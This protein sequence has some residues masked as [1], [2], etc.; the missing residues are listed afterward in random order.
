MSFL[1]KIFSSKKLLVTHSGRFHADDIFAT[2][3]LSLLLDGNIKVVR[4][5]DE[6][7][8]A[9]GDYVYDVG[10][11]YDEAI[12]RFDHHQVGGAG[13]RSNG[14]PYAAFG[15]VWKKYGDVVCGGSHDVAHQI[16]KKLVQ[17]IDANDN[18]MDLFTLKGETAPYLVQD[19]FSLWRPSFT[20]EAEYDVPFMKM[21][22]LAKEMLVREIKKTSDAVAGEAIVIDAYQRALDKRIIILDTPCPWGDVL[23]LYAEPLYVVYEKSDDSW[24]VS[25]VRKDKHSYENRKSLPQ[26]W[27]GLR[28]GE[29]AKVSGVPD[30][31]FCHNA[32]FLAVA[33]SKEGAVA[34]A[35]KALLA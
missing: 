17:P 26:S 23:G 13:V 19:V 3:T 28:D 6:K 21:V 2:A 29:M 5:R 4:T 9:K 7:I 35:Q 24:G 11:V 30:A 31:V 22:E 12:N 8:I 20:E 10:G 32:R 16:N 25:C 1:N 34:L 15:L 18:G 27:A 33:K 14:V